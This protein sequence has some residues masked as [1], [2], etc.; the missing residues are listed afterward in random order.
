MPGLDRQIIRQAKKIQ[1]ELYPYD[2][3][4]HLTCSYS[5]YWIEISVY[6]RLKIFCVF[7]RLPIIGP[8]AK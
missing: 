2:Y 1:L 5:P 4:G 8:L 3:S 7:L 6:F